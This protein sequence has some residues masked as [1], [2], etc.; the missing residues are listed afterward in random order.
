MESRGC[1]QFRFNKEEDVKMV[2]ANIPYQYGRLMIIV[3]RWEPIISPNFPAQIPFWISLRGI[4]LH[5]WH[6]KVVCNIGLEL[7]ELETYEVTR[8]AAADNG[9]IHG[10]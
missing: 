1:F 4:P 10:L 9:S 8:S 3:Q 5:Y 7:G 2:L 6:E